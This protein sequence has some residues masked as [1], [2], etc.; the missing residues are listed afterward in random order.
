MK[1]TNPTDNK[2]EIQ[3]RGIKYSVDA[4]DSIDVSKDVATFWKGI[5]G[6]LEVSEGDEKKETK[7]KGKELDKV[8]DEELDKAIEDIVKTTK[9][10]K[11]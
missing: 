3:F 10:N 6:F 4:K 1:I 9:T 7:V 8:S 2:I 11:K 5:H